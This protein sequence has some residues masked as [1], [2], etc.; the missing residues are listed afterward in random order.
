MLPVIEVAETRFGNRI[1]IKNSGPNLTSYF[2]Y[3]EATMYA[4]LKWSAFKWDRYKGRNDHNYVQM[5][6]YKILKNDMM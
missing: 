4:E 6:R 1:A 5:R 3:V 2:F